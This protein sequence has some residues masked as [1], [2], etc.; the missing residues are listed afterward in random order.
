MSS[1]RSTAASLRIPQT[2]SD[3][4]RFATNYL[5]AGNP[6]LRRQTPTRATCIDTS[7]NRKDEMVEVIPNTS[8]KAS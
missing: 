3:A 1:P 4:P 8:L 5:R 7:A 6:A 2:L